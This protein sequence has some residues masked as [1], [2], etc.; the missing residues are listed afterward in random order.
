VIYAYLDFRATKTATQL[1]SYVDL[2]RAHRRAEM[3]AARRRVRSFAFKCT[4]EDLDPGAS[5]RS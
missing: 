4:L 5:Q 3:L 2:L 1:E